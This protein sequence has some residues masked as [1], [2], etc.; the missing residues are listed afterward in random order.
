MYTSSGISNLCYDRLKLPFLAMYEKIMLQSDVCCRTRWGTNQLTKGSYSFIAVGST[1]QDILEL[2]KP[3][4]SKGVS[5]VFV[6]GCFSRTCMC[7]CACSYIH[8]KLLLQPVLKNSTE[9]Y[10]WSFPLSSGVIFA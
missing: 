9:G 3:L 10:W 6:I 4:S 8:N 7:V 5:K 2:S 1:Q